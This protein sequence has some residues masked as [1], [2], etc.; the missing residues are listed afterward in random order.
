MKNLRQSLFHNKHIYKKGDRFRYLLGGWYDWFLKKLIVDYP[1]LYNLPYL[2]RA[3]RKVQGYTS[4]IGMKTFSYCKYKSNT[5]ATGFQ[6]GNITP[7][8]PKFVVCT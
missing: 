2:H 5:S 1:L 8:C 7:N 3:D 4:R 6:K